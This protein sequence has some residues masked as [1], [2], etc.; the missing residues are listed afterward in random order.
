[1]SYAAP[2]RVARGPRW[3][4]GGLVV[5]AVLAGLWL[6]VLRPAPSGID[7]ARSLVAWD[8][9]CISVETTRDAESADLVAWPQAVER[10]TTF[11]HNAGPGLLYA[12][13]PDQAALRAD[14]L[15]APP[16]LP[17]CL[18]G[19]EVLLDLLDPGEFAA[20]CRE[21]EGRLVDGTAGVPEAEGATMDE[22]DRSIEIERRRSAAAQGRA[23][24]RLWNVAG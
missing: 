2:V 18:T 17:V 6:L 21:L 16:S 13:F 14:L 11:C 19:T 7:R 5:A 23:L 1:M 22:I 8:P 4:V 9:T 10:A 3:I 15:K 24:R 20:L 12:R